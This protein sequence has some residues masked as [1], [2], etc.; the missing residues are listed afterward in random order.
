PT[1]FDETLSTL[2]FATITSKIENKVKVNKELQFDMDQMVGQFELEKK[3]LLQCI[4]DL[5]ESSTEKDEV[6][7][8][9]NYVNWQNNY[10]DTLAFTNKVT[11]KKLDANL[12]ASQERNR[13]LMSSLISA[14]K[15]A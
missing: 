2:R 4:T 12:K 1:D 14:V 9:E 7:K 6:K 3:K 8:L 11:L 13:L 15:P 10:I 5:K